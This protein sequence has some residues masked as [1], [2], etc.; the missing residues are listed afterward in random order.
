MTLPLSDARPAGPNGNLKTLALSNFGVIAPRLAANGYRPVP[1]KPDTKRPAMAGWPSFRIDDAAIAEY[2]ECGTGLLCGQL[3]GVDVDVM[4]A[5]AAAEL[6]E[7]ARTELGDGPSRIGQAPKLL[8]AYRTTVPFRKKQ[9]CVFLIDGH[10]SKVEVLADGQQFVAY[11]IHPDTKAPYCWPAGDPLAVPFADL[12]EVSEEAIAAFVTKAEAILAKYGV[13]EKPDRPVTGKPSPHCK[14]V[15]DP[16]GRAYVEAALADE[17]K[18]VATAFAG[19]RNDTLNTAALK[20]GQLVAG[21]WLDQSRVERSLEDAA[22]ANGLGR[23]DG[24][25]SIRDTIKSGLKAGAR[26]PRDPPER[27]GAT[28]S[29]YRSNGASAAPEQDATEFTPPEPRYPDPLAEEA[30]Y[31]IAGELVRAIEP[32]SEA[33]PAAIL[34]QFLVCAGNAIGRGPYFPIEA[35]QHRTNLF[36]V[37]VGETSQGRKGTS[38]GWAKR[39]TVAADPSWEN[40][41]T[42]GLASGEGLIHAVRDTRYGVD[43]KGEQIVVDEG[44]VDKRLLV[45]EEEFARVLRVGSR[46]GNILSSVVRDAW[47]GKTLRGLSKNSPSKA[48]GAHISIIGH[49]TREE[50]L[51][52]MS[53]GDATNGVGNRFLWVFVKRSKLLPFGGDA[54]AGSMTSRRN[55]TAF[56]TR[57]RSTRSLSTPPR[58]GHGWRSAIGKAFRR[59]M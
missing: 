35:D 13:P 10:A 54:P 49:I 6:H 3:L 8:V 24:L 55:S 53:G 1:I 50:L 39:T 28:M 33:D 56:S 2:W 40:G 46:E 42:S 37:L 19:G 51:A 34:I 59:Y 18:R 25:K 38:L 41:I 32:H 45:V 4:H 27:Q 31:G 15:D 52:N 7:L 58:A 14:P 22:A 9:T 21:G 20:L 12:P 30:Y 17:V 57:P 48:S 26:D 16:A 47:D 11:A 23:D 44:V 43:K 29:G 5:E 36:A